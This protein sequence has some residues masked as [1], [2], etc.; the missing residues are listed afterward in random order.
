M[1]TKTVSQSVTFKTTPHEVY[2]AIMDSKKHSEFTDSQA[3]MSRKTG[4]KFSVYGGD[5]AGVNL[6]LIPDQKIVQ[7][8][9]YSDWPEGHYSKVTFSLKAV[10]EGT[11][12]TFTQTEVPD[13]H[14]EDIAQG[15]RDYYWAPMKEMLEK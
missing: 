13:E 3:S 6:E 4:G 9:R 7:S 12:L 1:K 14:Y 11:R 10:K 5:I 8:W 15:W 2:E